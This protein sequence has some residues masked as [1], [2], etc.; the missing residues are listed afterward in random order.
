MQQDMLQYC[1][2]G[3][4]GKLQGPWRAT[5]IRANIGLTFSIIVLELSSSS[6]ILQCSLGAVWT[7]P[8]LSTH[9]T[10]ECS[11][12]ISLTCSAL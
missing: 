9:A 12:Y 10:F 1:S 4:A 5:W 8:I 11:Y 6:G 7:A 3:S 2:C